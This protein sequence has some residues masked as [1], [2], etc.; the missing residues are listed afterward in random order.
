MVLPDRIE[1]STSP[2]PMVGPKVRNRCL[3]D[4]SHTVF[5]HRTDFARPDA[6][7]KGDVSLGA[8]KPKGLVKPI[9]GAF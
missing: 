3:S 2:L 9:Y 6:F 8:P 5:E 1:L 4:T 7:S